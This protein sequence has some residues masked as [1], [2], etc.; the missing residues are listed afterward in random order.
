[1]APRLEE[2]SEAFP[3]VKFVKVNVDENGALARSYGVRGIPTLVLFEEG[4][5]G[6]RITGAVPGQE[7]AD[8]IEGTFS[9]SAPVS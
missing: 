1:M 4:K 7:L 5:P 8:T 6:E 2:L 3:E 9:G